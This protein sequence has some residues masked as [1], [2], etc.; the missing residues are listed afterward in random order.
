MWSVIKIV[1]KYNSEVSLKARRQLKSMPVTFILHDFAS[2]SHVCTC[3][4][5]YTV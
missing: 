4:H 2:S 3:A 1:K 5:N